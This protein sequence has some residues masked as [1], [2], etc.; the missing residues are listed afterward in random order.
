M[1]LG[2][3]ESIAGGFEKALE[4]G[5]EDTCEGIQVFTKNSNQWRAK[6]LEDAEVERFRAAYRESPI[7][8]LMAHDSYLI[9]LASPNPDAYSKSRV[10]FKEE[11]ERCD[12][13]G[14]P[15]LVMH[16]G[17]HLG[18]GEGKAIERIASAMTEIIDESEIDS[19]SILI[20]TAA[21]QGTNVGYSFEHLADLIDLFEPKE[22]VGICFD[23]CHV[24][25]A[26]YDFRTP[27]G[28][29]Q[30]MEEFDRI[31]GL[32]W[33]KGFH[34]NDSKGDLGCRVDRH[35][36]IGEGF[37]GKEPFRFFLKDE[38]FKDVPGVL[39]TPPDKGGDR[40]FKKNL[41][42]MRSLL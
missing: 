26:G 24:F 35:E 34:I 8:F 36:Q 30:T 32:K 7:S 4:R 25:A 39:E 13:L 9:N 41:Q 3:H 17:A 11:L 21:G 38:R 20:E 19:V 29:Q 1:R 28:Y 40:A 31:I 42:R 14:I 15:Y 10:A 23:T 33:I 18:E 12:R 5:E 27:R 22:Q 6:P 16:P 2:A 37:I